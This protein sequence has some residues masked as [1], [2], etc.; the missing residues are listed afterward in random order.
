MK[1][2]QIVKK[3]IRVAGWNKETPPNKGIYKQY[4]LTVDQY[5]CVHSKT[6]GILEL[7]R[8]GQSYGLY[9]PCYELPR[10]EKLTGLTAK[11]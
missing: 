7:E 6:Y 2:I 4:K 8:N 9:I 1:N 3:H 5:G 11:E 10:I